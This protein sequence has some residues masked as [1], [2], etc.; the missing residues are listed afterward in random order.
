MVHTRAAVNA[1]IL[2][3]TRLRTFWTGFVHNRALLSH[4]KVKSVICNNLVGPRGH[5]A[6][7]RK[8]DRGRQMSRDP[9]YMW[10][11]KKKIN[12]TESDL[13]TETLLTA[14]SWRGLAGWVR[15]GE[16]VR[17]TDPPPHSGC[18]D[19]GCS[20]GHTASNTVVTVVSD[21]C[22]IHWGDDSARY[23]NATALHT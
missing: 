21:G 11:V 6:E 17:S 4:K 9:I 15:E 2:P 8:S 12:R 1:S 14:A 22:L 19:V 7:F 18:R 13:Q 3:V 5:R 16:G 20:V 10:N 23:I